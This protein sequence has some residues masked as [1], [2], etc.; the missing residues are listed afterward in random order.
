MS[1]STCSSDE[2]FGLLVS[3]TVRASSF[4]DPCSDASDGTAASSSLSFDRSDR[5]KSKSP[6]ARTMKRVLFSTY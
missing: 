2:V 5:V 3:V 6:A 4:E 1:T